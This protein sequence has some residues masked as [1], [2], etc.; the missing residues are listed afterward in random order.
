VTDAS[1]KSLENMAAEF[2]YLGTTG[3]DKNYIRFEIEWTL[4]SEMFAYFQL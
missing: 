4:S 1:N 2:R 3:R